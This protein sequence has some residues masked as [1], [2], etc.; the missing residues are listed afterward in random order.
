MR[1]NVG[2][3][4]Q[5]V[6]YSKFVWTQ[7][8]EL[9][10]SSYSSIYLLFTILVFQV[11]LKNNNSTIT[12]K[13][14]IV[15]LY[16]VGSNV[17]CLFCDL[18]N[19]YITMLLYALSIDKTLHCSFCATKKFFKNHHNFF[20]SEGLAFFSAMGSTRSETKHSPRL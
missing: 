15:T 12:H 1:H 18:F 7:I 2:S 3:H 19:A 10:K 17:D 16:L 20:L 9:M 14:L 5:A 6:S 4:E 13:N 8:R 11:P